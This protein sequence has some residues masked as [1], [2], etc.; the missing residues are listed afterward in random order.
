M[1]CVRCENVNQ[2]SRVVFQRFR[3][4]RVWGCLGC[5]LGMRQKPVFLLNLSDVD[6]FPATV[7]S[8]KRQLFPFEGKTCQA[9]SSAKWERDAFV[10]I[11]T[12]GDS[13]SGLALQRLTILLP[14]RRANTVRSLHV[15]SLS[16]TWCATG[17]AESLRCERSFLCPSSA[18][19]SYQ[20]L[21]VD[22]LRKQ[23]DI[24]DFFV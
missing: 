9:S 7:S 2:K 6:R 8:F 1:F 18:R 15:S 3:G 10:T 13:S 19:S 4:I 5:K 16:A 20:P 24:E 17:L 14:S 21:N 23:H 22:F 11:R 12:L